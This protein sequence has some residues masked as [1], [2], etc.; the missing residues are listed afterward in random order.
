MDHVR[1]GRRGITEA[2]P[3]VRQPQP[4]GGGKAL[5]GTPWRMGLS[6]IEGR[7]MPLSSGRGTGHSR[8]IGGVPTA[9]CLGGWEARRRRSYNGNLICGILASLLLYQNEM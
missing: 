6:G 5:G 9:P 4:L 8:A 1:V 7:W 2:R 3:R